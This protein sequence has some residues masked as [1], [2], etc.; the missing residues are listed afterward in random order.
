[1]IDNEGKNPIGPITLANMKVIEQKLYHSDSCTRKEFQDAIQAQ[2]ENRTS[3]SISDRTIQNLIKYLND[4]YDGKNKI[5]MKRAIDKNGPIYTIENRLHLRFP[6]VVNECSEGDRDV[7]RLLLQIASLHNLPVKELS[8]RISK[9]IDTD[10]IDIQPKPFERF[11]EFFGRLFDAMINR[12]VKTI[13]YKT[14]NGISFNKIISPLMLKCYNNRWYLIA[15]AHADSNE[16]HPF[17]WSIFPLDRIMN[18]NDYDQK[19]KQI[20]F[21]EIRISRIKEYYSKVIG[22]DVPWNKIRGNSK[23][24]PKRNLMPKDL[25]TTPIAIKF[26]NDQTF[27]YIMNNPIH[28]S[29]TAKTADRIINLDVVENDSLYKRLL[30]IGGDIEDITPKEV[31]ERLQKV[32]SNIYENITK[33][34]QISANE[35]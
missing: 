26:N 7:L 15:H 11:E 10:S 14:K 1:M 25:I 35:L 5:V 13:S 9:S 21:Y 31:M 8:E 32:V 33:R 4:W 28:T 30:V 20:S 17:D 6:E 19:G 18:V 23:E 24:D 12:K 22:F 29:Q 34:N 16:K 27:K 3:K 2:I